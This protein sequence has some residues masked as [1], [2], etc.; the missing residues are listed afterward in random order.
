M[1]CSVVLGSVLPTTVKGERAKL[2]ETPVRDRMKRKRTEKACI[3]HIGLNG[4]DGGFEPT[5]PCG[6]NDFEPFV[7][8][9]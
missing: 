9:T 3:G 5:D 2:T 7:M 4:G 1:Q 6:S 8:T